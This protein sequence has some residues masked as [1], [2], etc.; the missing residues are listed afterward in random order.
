MLKEKSPAKWKRLMELES[1]CTERRG[2]DQWRIDRAGVAKFIPRFFK[3][4]SKWTEDEIL[5]ITGILQVNA[6]EVPLSDPPY[7]AIYDFASFAE[8]SCRPN[9]TKSFSD[10][11]EIIFWAP[12]NIKKGERLSICYTDS[13]WG[14]ANRQNHLLQTKMFKCDCPRCTDVTE[15]QTFYSSIKCPNK[16]DDVQCDGLMLPSEL[17]TMEENWIC[18]KCSHQVENNYVKNILERAGKDIAAMQKD[19]KEHCVKYLEHYSKWLPE[20]H[21]HM[22]DVKLAL[23]QLIGAGGPQ[24][25]QQIS[26]DTLCEKIKIG[27]DLLKIFSIISPG[28][29]V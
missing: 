28:K 27:H 14:T 16:V 15:F 8:H 20:C 13:L 29:F 4:E 2:S 24:K 17:S 23:V 12:H 22:C 5:K 21:Y 11:G 1:H 18:R 6:H 7:V 19:S 25:I 9:M 3:C 26:E 10:K